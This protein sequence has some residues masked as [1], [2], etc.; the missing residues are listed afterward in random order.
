M[1]YFAVMRVKMNPTKFRSPLFNDLK[2]AFGKE[3]T[4]RIKP[5]KSESVKRFLESL[6][7][8]EKEAQE[9]SKTQYK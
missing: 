4:Q 7:R 9:N 5:D 3:Q 8:W 1:I 6:D 2:K